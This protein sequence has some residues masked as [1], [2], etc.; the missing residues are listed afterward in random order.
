MS[1]IFSTLKKAMVDYEDE[2]VEVYLPK[3][4]ITS[5]FTLNSILED[6]SFTAKIDTNVKRDIN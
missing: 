2:E 1:R 3:F 6:V 4:T 5:D